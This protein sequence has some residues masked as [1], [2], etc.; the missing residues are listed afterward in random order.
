MNNSGIIV[1]VNSIAKHNN[2]DKL[3]I[4]HIFGTQ[5][6]TG[7][8]TKA[9]DLM[10]Y[11][12]SN[13]KLSTEYLKEHNLY[14]HSE[15]NKDKNEV[16]YFEENGRVK[17]IKLRGEFSD[18]VLMP[19]DSLAFTGKIDKLVQGFEF[20]DFNGVKICEKYIP[21]TKTPGLPREKKNS[22]R[23]TPKSPM[24][25]EHW[26]T[27]QF[28]KNQH[29]I[30][31]HTILYIEEKVHGTSGRIG[32][33]IVETSNERNW[34][35]RFLMTKICGIKSTWVYRCI[36]G[37]RRV[38]FNDPDK[39]YNHFHDPTMREKVLEKVT[40][41][42]DKGQ[43][44][45]FELYGYEA[46]G[47]EI[48]K[49]FPYGCVA[50]PVLGDTTSKQYK[51]LLYRVTMN[52]EDGKVIDYSREYVYGKADELGLEKPYLFEKVYYDGTE[53][54]MKSLE[55]KVVNYAQGQS[56]LDKNTLKEGVVIWFINNKGNWEA[57]KYKQDA[58]R[59]KESS[60]K[61]KGIIDQEDIN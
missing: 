22:G 33:V 41:L 16:G 53:E 24:F 37:S 25:V 61:D 51:T 52:N 18:G 9:G 19:I 17:A 27:G 32:N 60:N 29:V 26:D 57:L 15:L 59:L 14:R 38:T 35:Q 1:V 5:V 40:G 42:L 12:D 21:I 56:E 3:Q 20:N 54:S 36:H 4:V 7:L 34:F 11:F 58:F 31:A 23:K 39:K 46:T 8:D 48:Q 45:Y 28:F 2:A 6:I 50:K 47:A 10:I 55:E 49:G 43:E 30:P 44:I 13:L